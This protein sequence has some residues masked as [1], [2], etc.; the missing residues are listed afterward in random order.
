M[1][2]EDFRLKFFA[3]YEQEF[4]CYVHEKLYENENFLNLLALEKCSKLYGWFHSYF[5]P[6]SFNHICRLWSSLMHDI[7]DDG[8]VSVFIYNI[9]HKYSD[10]IETL[11]SKSHIKTDF[12][13]VEGEI[14]Y[15]L[16]EEKLF[17]I[18]TK[19]DSPNGSMFKSVEMVSWKLVHFDWDSLKF[20]ASF[21]PEY[22]KMI[23]IA[24]EESRNPKPKQADELFRVPGWYEKNKEI[25]EKILN[26][27]S[28]K[29]YRTSEKWAVRKL[30]F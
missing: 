17:K 11:K 1:N 28:E 2:L 20:L 24:E 13:M 10:D 14:G 29:P 22:K 7:E 27:F 12:T 21:V 4:D 18:A 23:E 16:T 15:G 25:Q 19:Y 30:N 5:P 26:H 6:D 9:E 3:K 8:M